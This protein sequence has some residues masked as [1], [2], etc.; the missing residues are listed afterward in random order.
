[1]PQGFNVT[2]FRTGFTAH[3]LVPVD[4][5]F[6]FWFSIYLTLGFDDTDSRHG[7]SAFPDFQSTGRLLLTPPSTW[8]SRMLACGYFSLTTIGPACPT[9]WRPPNRGELVFFVLGVL[10]MPFGIYHR[11]FRPLPF[12]QAAE[13]W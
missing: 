13:P 11:H 3:R 7:F 4:R 2:D 10:C 12:V 8:F 5:F 1:M 9:T 6:C